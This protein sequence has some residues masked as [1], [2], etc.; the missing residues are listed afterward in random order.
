MRTF[1]FI[2][3][4]NKKKLENALAVENI[5]KRDLES[6]QETTLTTPARPPRHRPARLAQP[7]AAAVKHA[8]TDLPSPETPRTQFAPDEAKAAAF[9]PPQTP[10]NATRAPSPRAA[11]PPPPPPLTPVGT[12]DS[13]TDFQSA[14]SQSPTPDDDDDARNSI[15]FVPLATPPLRGGGVD[16]EPESV[17]GIMSSTAQRNL[18]TLISWTRARASSTATTIQGGGRS[19]SPTTPDM[20]ALPPPRAPT[21]RAKG[22]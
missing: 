6:D 22:P 3:K 15:D 20:P 11:S 13:D 17:R 18:E 4:K 8:R 21:P 19:A 7:I 12:E 1:F 14:Y 5:G 9:S 16:S 10:R 2:K